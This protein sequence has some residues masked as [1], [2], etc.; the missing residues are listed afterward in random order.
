MSFWRQVT[1]GFRRLIGGNERDREIDDEV[2]NFFEGLAATYR[3][4]VFAK[5]ML[6][7]Q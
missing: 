5:R 2:E 1:P 6:A 4:E 3:S 7:E